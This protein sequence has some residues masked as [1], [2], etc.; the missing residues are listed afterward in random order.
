[1]SKADTPEPSPTPAEGDVWQ[2]MLDLMP[3]GPMRVACLE[4]REFGVLRYGVPLQRDNGRDHTADLLQEL[5]DGMAYAWASD[6]RW[7]ARRLYE[8]AEDLL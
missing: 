8:M 1:M 2:E 3:E 7:V 5:L 4:R 6:R